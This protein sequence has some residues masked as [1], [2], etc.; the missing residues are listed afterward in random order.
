MNYKMNQEVLSKNVV[1]TVTLFLD[2]HV[3]THTYMQ[4]FSE[5]AC[6]AASVLQNCVVAQLGFFS[7]F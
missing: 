5:Q 6:Q 2:T 4:T 1:V 7:S 3:C